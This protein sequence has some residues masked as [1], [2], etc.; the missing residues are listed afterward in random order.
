MRIVLFGCLLVY[1]LRLPGKLFPAVAVVIDTGSVAVWGR[2]TTGQA[3]LLD[4]VITRICADM[5]I[6]EGQEYAWSTK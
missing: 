5:G 1:V 4:G 2:C 6:L 3:I